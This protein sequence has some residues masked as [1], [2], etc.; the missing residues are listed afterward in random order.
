MMKLKQVCVVHTIG[1]VENCLP[2]CHSALKACI[3]IYDSVWDRSENNDDEEQTD[4]LSVCLRKVK[5]KAAVGGQ[6]Y[7]CNAFSRAN[8]P[9]KI[10]F[11]MCLTT[12][13]LE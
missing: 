12:V 10:V 4:N 8:T 1:A 7:N 9:D 5:T 2:G 6:S 13:L 3:T 11:P